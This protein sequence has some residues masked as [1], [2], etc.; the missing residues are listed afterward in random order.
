MR[1]LVVWLGL[2]SLLAG[3]MTPRQ[4]KRLVTEP[5]PMPPVEAEATNPAAEPTSPPHAV[6]EPAAFEPPAAP[7][8]EPLSVSILLSDDVPEYRE[9]AEE[10]AGR[11]GPDRLHLYDLDGNAARVSSTLRAIEDSG[12]HGIVAVGLLAASA[13]RRLDDKNILFCQVFNYQDHDLIGPRHKGISMIP[14]PSQL[15]KVWREIDPDLRTVGAITGTG[16]EQLIAEARK[17]ARAEGL[18]LR[19]RVVSSDRE[20]LYEF[21]R[22]L[23]E[24]EGLWLVPDN[25]ILSR[26]VLSDIMSYCRKYR[27]QVLVNNPQLLAMGGLVSVSSRGSDVAAIAQHEL[28]RARSEGGFRGPDLLP[29]GDADVRVNGAVAAALGLSVP[30]AYQGLVSRP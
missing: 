27:K 10:L 2:L 7:E 22:L 13:A 6:P 17:A 4:R 14:P 25:R 11:L 16:H 28:E 30:A 21:R 18:E 20:A 24:I 26:D 1:H 8:D 12:D 5:A 3:C 29:L 9:V 19:H 15:M 23:P